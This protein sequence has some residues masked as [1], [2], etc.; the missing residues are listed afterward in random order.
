MTIMMIARE[1][2]RTAADMGA[3]VTPAPLAMLG[4]ATG[5]DS[6]VATLPE[7]GNIFSLEVLFERKY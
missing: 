3:T 4:E 7:I 1:T 6:C 5:M 2:T